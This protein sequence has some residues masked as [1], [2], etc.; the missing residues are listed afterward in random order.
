MTALPSNASAKTLVD[1]QTQ[2]GMCHLTAAEPDAHL[3]LVT[4]LQELG[5]L[6]HLG[7]EVVGVD[8]QGKADLLE[9]NTFWFFLASF[10]FFCISNRYLP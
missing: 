6:V 10:S 1:I 8:V 2:A 4:L 9:F 5:S 3:E 7:V